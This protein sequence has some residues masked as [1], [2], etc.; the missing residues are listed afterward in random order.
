ME[1]LNMIEYGFPMDIKQPGKSLFS[2]R[3]N[4]HRLSPIIAIILQGERHLGQAGPV[5]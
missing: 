4:G 5:R 3:E 1:Q 2:V